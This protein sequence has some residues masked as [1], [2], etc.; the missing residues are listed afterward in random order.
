MVDSVALFR[1]TLELFT[2]ILGRA[3]IDRELDAYYIFR[4]TWSPRSRW[5]HRRPT[6]SPI[7]PLIYWSTRESI[8]SLQGPFGFWGG[9]PE[10][11]LN[12]L[13]EEI[14]YFREYWASLPKKRGIDNLRWAL[15][16]AKRFFSLSHELSTG[17]WF[18]KREGVLVEPLFLDAQSSPGKPD[19]VVKTPQH[20]FGVQC[21]SEDPSAA[22]QMPYD[23][24]QYFAG[25]YQCAVEDSGRSYHLSL[26]L[27][28][29]IDKE[30][31]NRIAGAIRRTLGSDE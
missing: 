14:L 18:A 25:S 17:F 6:T 8:S 19:L 5:Y 11:I 3:W 10:E 9:Y 7:V 13:A 30:F 28:G 2:E 16:S 29:R 15:S 24:F 27:T 21:K 31:A 4:Q 12:R 23:V 22:K 1:Y 20:S 26:H